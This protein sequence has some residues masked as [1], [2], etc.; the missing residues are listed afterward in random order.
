MIGSNNL[1]SDFSASTSPSA[2][3]WWE[4]NCCI[5][6]KEISSLNA[7]Y[8]FLPL[9]KQQTTP[10]NVLFFQKMK[11]YTFLFS[12]QTGTGSQWEGPHNNNKATCIQ[13]KF[14]IHYILLFLLTIPLYSLN[15]CKKYYKTSPI[16]TFLSFSH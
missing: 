10:Y 12:F 13:S 11:K 9:F 3:N 2:F 15:L 4:E 6:L 8:L 5:F 16:Y 14:T 7:F 1:T